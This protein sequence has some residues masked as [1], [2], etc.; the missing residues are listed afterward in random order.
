MHCK[1]TFNLS[2]IKRQENVEDKQECGECVGQL[3]HNHVPHFYSRQKV[4]S[5]TFEFDFRLFI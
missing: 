1:T 5:F 3:E 4:N 2:Q